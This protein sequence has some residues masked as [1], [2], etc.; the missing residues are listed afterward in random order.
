MSA[1]HMI[2]EH[3]YQSFRHYKGR[4]SRD[5]GLTDGKHEQ[6]GRINT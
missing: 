6:K 5:E 3:E 4:M 2:V 1:L